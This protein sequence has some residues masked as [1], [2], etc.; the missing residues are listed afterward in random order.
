MR[1]ATAAAPPRSSSRRG[2]LC[3]RSSTRSARALASL[4]SRWRPCEE[5]EEGEEEE[6]QGEEEEE[7]GEKAGGARRGRNAMEEGGRTGR[8]KR[9]RTGRRKD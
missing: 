6:D 8:G 1:R 3:A 4:R 5:Q 2:S 7:E 9:R